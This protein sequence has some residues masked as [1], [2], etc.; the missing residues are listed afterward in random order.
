LLPFRT[1]HLTSPSLIRVAL[2]VTSGGYYAH[3]K[4]NMQDIRWSMQGYRKTLVGALS[5]EAI[6]LNMLQRLVKFSSM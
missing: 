3:T 6:M 4:E 1:K 2:S 5:S